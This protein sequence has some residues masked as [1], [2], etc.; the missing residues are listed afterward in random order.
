MSEGPMWGKSRIPATPFFPA[1]R[2]TAGPRAGIES[3]LR[4]ADKLRVQCLQWL[5]AGKDQAGCCEAVKEGNRL[6]SEFLCESP[7]LS[8]TEALLPLLKLVLQQTLPP[9]IVTQGWTL[10]DQRVSEIKEGA[11]DLAD[12]LGDDEDRVEAVWQAAER[13]TQRVTSE[14]EADVGSLALW[15]SYVTSMEDAQE[16]S[17]VLKDFRIASETLFGS[18][19]IIVAS[20]SKYRSRLEQLATTAT[21][22]P[23]SNPNLNPNNC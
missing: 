17:L 11:S 1:P 4:P 18:P 7:L 19:Q 21:G 12:Q 20:L 6:M 2:A 22:E 10:L 5:L 23:N 14:W 15:K 13:E 3:V 9:D 8:H 16:F